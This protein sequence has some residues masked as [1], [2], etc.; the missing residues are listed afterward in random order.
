MFPIMSDVCSKMT[1]FLNAELTNKPDGFDAKEV[2]SFRTLFFF[3]PKSYY[4]FL[5]LGAKFTTDVVSSCIYGSDSKSFTDRDSVIRK[6]GSSIFETTPKLVVYFILLQ[7]FPF[8]SKLI[9]IS[10]ISKKIE[11]FFTRLMDDAIKMRI[12]SKSQREDFLH[13]LLQLKEKRGLQPVDMAAHTLTFFLDG[14]ETS[15]SVIAQCLY[16][17]AKNQ[18]VQATVR[19]EI[20]QSLQKHGS[21]TFEGINE[22]GYLDQVFNGINEIFV[23][24]GKVLIRNFS[25]TLRIN[26]VIGF[27][28]KICTENTEI[29][30]FKDKKVLIEKDINVYIPIY[31]IHHDPEYYPNPSIFEPDRFRP[32][33]GGIKRYKDKGVFLP[34]GDGPR[35]CLGK[36]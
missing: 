29:R 5:K 9:K 32:E 15:S 3:D 10:M 28:S 14:F 11:L 19:H 2:S 27:A 24:M 1:T 30:D 12:E 21:I 22:M 20:E 31:S 35:I 25:E 4:F 8:L 34:W 16:Q 17:L 23:F 18:D 7:V 26:P 13:Y 36:V 33:I 6:M